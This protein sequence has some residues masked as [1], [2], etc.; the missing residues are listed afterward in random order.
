[1]ASFQ[2]A[3]SRHAGDIIVVFSGDPYLPHLRVAEH[4]PLTKRNV[5]V[6]SVA[7]ELDL[8]D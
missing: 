8:A 4:V 1:M 2:A 7:K 6:I 5:D 3:E